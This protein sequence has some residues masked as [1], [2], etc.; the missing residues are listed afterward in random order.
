MSVD[1]FAR[2][3][4][5]GIGC[6][7]SGPDATSLITGVCCSYYDSIPCLFFKVQ[8]GQFHIKNNV[9]HRQKDYNVIDHSKKHLNSIYKF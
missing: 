2:I 8:V 5:F 7:T 3:N 4:G 1:A 6:V 9:H